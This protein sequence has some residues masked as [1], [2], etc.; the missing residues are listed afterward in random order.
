MLRGGL[1]WQ[2]SLAETA[3][4]VT[5]GSRRSQRDR[6]AKTC[7]LRN[8]SNELADLLA[9]RPGFDAGIDP[10]RAMPPLPEKHVCPA[11]GWREMPP[12]AVSDAD[13]MSAPLLLRT[14]VR[15]RTT[16]G[17]RA[18]YP[19]HGVL[20]VQ[21]LRCARSGANAEEP[22][23]ESTEVGDNLFVVSH[24]TGIADLAGA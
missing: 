3:T 12:H 7:R 11:R 20:I 23:V 16:P 2:R 24:D 17:T 1:F 8:I 10:I 15:C 14:R 21:F 18:R 13:K 19:R 22:G 9:S 4:F 6:P 5:R